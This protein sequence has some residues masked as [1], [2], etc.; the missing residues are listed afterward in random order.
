MTNGNAITLPSG[1][2]ELEGITFPYYTS[3]NGYRLPD[4][5]RLDISIKYDVGGLLQSLFSNGR[6][7]ETSLEFSVYNVYNRRNINEISFEN[8]G[9]GNTAET[10]D[11]SSGKRL[12]AYGTSYFGIMPSLTFNFKF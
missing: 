8:P 5:H 7:Y 12:Q 3:R 2:Y 9:V 10:K 1:Q 4:N 11:G 6:R